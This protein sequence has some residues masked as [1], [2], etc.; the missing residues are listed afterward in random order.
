[1]K[2]KVYEIDEFGF[3]KEIYVANVDIN[4]NILDEDKVNFIA[5]DPQHGLFKARWNGAQWIEGATQEEIEELTRVEPSPQTEIELLKQENTLLKAQ[6]QA[7]SERADFHEELI[8]E[9]AMM[10][11]P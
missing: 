5:T 7:T 10:I 4:G 6:V 2:R 11:I 9:L 1:M 8:A 3:L